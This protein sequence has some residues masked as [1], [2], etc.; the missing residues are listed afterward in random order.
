M[1]QFLD[2]FTKDKVDILMN[3]FDFTY[4]DED[5]NDIPVFETGLPVDKIM[6][7]TSDE[8]ILD[9]YDE[10]KTTCSYLKN[11]S[12]VNEKAFEDRFND[13]KKYFEDNYF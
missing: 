10:I 11:I 7:E 12:Q 9:L 5:G 3:K 8:S 4:K 13:L 6:L 1:S 2:I